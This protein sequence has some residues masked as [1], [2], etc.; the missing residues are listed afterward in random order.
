[1]LSI[2]G[3]EAGRSQLEFTAIRSRTY[4]IESSTDME[5]WTPVSFQV[6]T[7]AEQG[8]YVS[9]DVRPVRVSVGSGTEATEAR[10]APRFFKVMVH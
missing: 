5:T 2:L 6:G 8:S 7:G 4:T 10:E 9:R 1:M 3:V